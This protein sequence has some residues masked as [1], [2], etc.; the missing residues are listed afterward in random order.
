MRNLNRIFLFE[1][2]L[3]SPVVLQRQPQPRYIYRKLIL[4]CYLDFRVKFD[5]DLQTL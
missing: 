2:Q 4:K 1:A 3:K 5:G